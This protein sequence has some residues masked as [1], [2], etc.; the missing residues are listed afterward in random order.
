MTKQA[1]GIQRLLEWAY[2]DELPFARPPLDAM[3]FAPAAPRPG[4]AAMAGAGDARVSDGRPALNSWGVVA[5]AG[6]WRLPHPDAERVGLAVQALDRWLLGLPEG[7]AADEALHAGI[8]VEG[9]GDLTDLEWSAAAERALARLTM[10]ERDGS[11]VLRR[12]ISSLIIRA[13]T[14]GRTPQAGDGSVK[15]RVVMAGNNKPA[16]FVRE[17][18]EVGTS[19][20]G[21]PRMGEVEVSGLMRNGRPKPGAYQKFV[22]EPDPATILIERAEYEVWRAALDVLAED[23][24]DSLDAWR[25]KASRL[26]FRPWIEEGPPIGR[27]LP[28]SGKP[29]KHRPREQVI[30]GPPLSLWGRPRR[31]PARK[32]KSMAYLVE[33]STDSV[34]QACVGIE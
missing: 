11:T 31:Q 30:A 14:Q 27:V 25:I 28:A 6:N 8:R 9:E 5:M 4:W 34:A 10:R 17:L 3:A 13:A 7:W 21:T 16:W 29:V 22:V 23:L 26:P 15:R 33:Q 18:A 19:A 32:I 12:P 20:D 24:G 2:R 1:I